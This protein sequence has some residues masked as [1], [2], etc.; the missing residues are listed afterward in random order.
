MQQPNEPAGIADRLFEPDDRFG[1]AG[2]GVR[3]ERCVF[4][5]AEGFVGGCY[6]EDEEEGVGGAREEGEEGW[7]GEGVDVVVGEGGGEAEL[8]D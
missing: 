5:R 7:L 1:G 6:G 3:R 4:G 8:V 2:A